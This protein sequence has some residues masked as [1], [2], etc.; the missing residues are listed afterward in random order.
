MASRREPST[1]IFYD[2]ESFWLK[3]FTTQATKSTQVSTKPLP[4]PPPVK[5]ERV[6]PLE[7]TNQQIEEQTQQVKLVPHSTKQ[8]NSN[9]KADKSQSLDTIRYRDIFN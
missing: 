1:E 9:K 2:N 3:H 5:V 7:K 8:S 6:T 4:S